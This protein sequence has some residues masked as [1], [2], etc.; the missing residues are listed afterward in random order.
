MLHKKLNYSFHD[1]TLIS[2]EMEKE[3]RLLIHLRLDG[4]TYPD[5]DPLSL[6]FS[7][8]LNAGEVKDYFRAIESYAHQPGWHGTRIDDLD[9]AP[10]RISK[11]LDLY[12]IL[13]LDGYPPLVIH[14]KKL[15]ITSEH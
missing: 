11:T 10:D 5:H 8:I 14:C 9:Y 2:A 1:A 6:T 7:G 4:M 12:L 3:D 13:A 15:R